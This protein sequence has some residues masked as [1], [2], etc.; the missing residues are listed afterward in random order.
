M[1]KGCFTVKKVLFCEFC[2]KELMPY[3]EIYNVDGKEITEYYCED[4]DCPNIYIIDDETNFEESYNYGFV[5]K[6][7]FIIHSKE[8]NYVRG[9]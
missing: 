4:E 6:D 7:V 5:V 8:T 1:Y 2:G 9:K 3:S